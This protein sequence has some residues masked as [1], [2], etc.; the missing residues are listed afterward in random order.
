MQHEALLLSVRPI[1]AD[2]ILSG[3]KSVELRRVRPGVSSGH[4]VLIYCSTPRMELLA[5][6]VVAHVDEGQ[7]KELWE[8]V[9]GRAGVSD[10]EYRAYFQGARRAV[11]IW[12]ADVTAF[13]RPVP[14]KEMRSRWPWF[15][16]P[17]SYCY[18]NADIR[19]TRQPSI[20]PRE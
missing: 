19:G 10:V 8:R 3:T 14:L 1:Y 18:V 12:L 9:K 20:A 15:R 7:P 6:A 5:S 13:A 11:G 16:P 4:R 17:Q 2:R